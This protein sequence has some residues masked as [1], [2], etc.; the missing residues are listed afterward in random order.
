[1]KFP[2]LRKWSKFW[3]DY[4]LRFIFRNGP[5]YLHWSIIWTHWCTPY[6]HLYFHPQ[7]AFECGLHFLCIHIDLTLWEVENH[8]EEVC[9]E[10]NKE[11]PATNQ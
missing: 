5:P 9:E 8:E 10:A 1:M 2:N 11:N 3:R 6:I 4:W 7:L